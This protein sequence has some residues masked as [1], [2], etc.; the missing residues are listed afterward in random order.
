MNVILLAYTPFIDP[1]N[2]HSTWFWLLL[3]LALGVSVVYKALRVGDMRHY[4]RQVLAMTIQ[5]VVVMVLL[6]IASYVLIQHVVPR[7]LPV[8]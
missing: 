4:V 3:P 2:V 8:T 1:I 5:I 7:I 6:G